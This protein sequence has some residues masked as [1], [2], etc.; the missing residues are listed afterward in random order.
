MS[1]RK[2]VIAVAV[3]AGI[4]L[5]VVG[6]AVAAGGGSATPSATPGSKAAPSSTATP[7][8]RHHNCPHMGG[9]GGA[10]TSNPGP[11]GSGDSVAL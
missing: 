1:I 3:T 5:S 11:S 4:A 8:G 9:G 2:A 6:I 10:G 7:Y